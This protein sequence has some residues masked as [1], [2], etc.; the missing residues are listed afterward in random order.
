MFFGG[1][2]LMGRIPSLLLLFYVPLILHW[3]FW[4][5]KQIVKVLM[6]LFLF[7]IS[8]EMVSFFLKGHLFW[9][10]QTG[11]Q[12]ISYGSPDEATS[13]LQALLQAPATTARWG[14]MLIAP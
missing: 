13:G 4:N 8:V 6:F 2:Q 11:G 10:Y 5:E 1:L 14:I 9:S 7:D 3:L 12:G